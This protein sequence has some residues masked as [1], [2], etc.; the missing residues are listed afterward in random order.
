MAENLAW[1]CLGK[2]KTY[3]TAYKKDTLQTV[4]SLIL[5]YDLMSQVHL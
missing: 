5:N 1:Q 2:C 4:I 3:I